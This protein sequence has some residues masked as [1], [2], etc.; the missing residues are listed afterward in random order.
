M[1]LYTTRRP[2]SRGMNPPIWLVADSNSVHWPSRDNRQRPHDPSLGEK[3]GARTLTSVSS[4]TPRHHTHDLHSGRSSDWHTP[5][6]VPRHV[7]PDRPRADHRTL[8]GHG[9]APYQHRPHTE[10][11]R[12]PLHPV[13]LSLP[14]WEAPPVHSCSPRRL[15][16]TSQ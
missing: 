12:R 11:W 5:F 6:N 4:I 3:E 2:L 10:F 9:F 16:N 7:L 14:H 15:M 8:H 13:T 1:S